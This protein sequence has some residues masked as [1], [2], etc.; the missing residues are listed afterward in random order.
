MPAIVVGIIG[1]VVVA[2]FAPHVFYTLL[3]I[4]VAGGGFILYLDAKTSPM[5]LH[6]SHSDEGYT[7][8]YRP[9]PPEETMLDVTPRANTQAARRNGRG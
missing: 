5:Y 1:T 7:V 9:V 4:V 6:S 8:S 3:A 2:I